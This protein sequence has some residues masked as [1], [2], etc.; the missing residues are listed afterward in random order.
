MTSPL[1][2]PTPPAAIRVFLGFRRP[3]LDR[4]RFWEELGHTFMPGTPLMQAPLG[5]SAYLPAVLDAA[6]DRG[7]PDEVAII[8]Y[9]SREIYDAKR[10][11]SLSRRMY[12]HSHVA[13]FDME[14]SR[15]QFAA[16]LSAP[17]TLEQEG[18]MTRAWYVADEAVDWQDGVTY[19]LFLEAADPSAAFADAVLDAAHRS[20]ALL[21]DPGCDQ[22]VG[23]CAPTYAAMWVHV[24]EPL[25]GV[26]NTLGLV[27]EGVT[28]VHQLRCDRAYVRGDD[29]AGVTITGATAFSFL[30]QRHLAYFLPE[31]ASESDG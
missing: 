15:A 24:R 8:V 21:A 14:R 4:A 23:V 29:E 17:S 2:L 1:A 3:A 7:H 31:H 28:L 26:A 25:A 18:V 12:T 16:P 30:F 13:V 5:L 20:R 22:V 27:P 9:A 10:A 6:P 11:A 19:V